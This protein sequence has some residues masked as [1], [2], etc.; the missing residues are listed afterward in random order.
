[1]VGKTILVDFRDKRREYYKP[2][3]WL[4]APYGRD[5]R[6]V[7]GT[8]RVELSRRARRKDVSKRRVPY[9]HAESPITLV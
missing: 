9:T 1:M 6:G 7:R 8:H 2:N 4:E 3:N 5:K